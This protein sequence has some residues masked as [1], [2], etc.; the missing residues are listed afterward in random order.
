QPVRI[1]PVQTRNRLRSF[2]MLTRREGASADSIDK[3][4]D[5]WLPMRAGQAHVVGGALVAEGRR[6]RPVYGEPVASKRELQLGERRW[7]FMAAMRH[8]LE[9]RDGEMASAVHRIGR[10]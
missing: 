7:P 5:A 3:H 10:W 9:V 2:D 6:D 1:D 4:L 8:G